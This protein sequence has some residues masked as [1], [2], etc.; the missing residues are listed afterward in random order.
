MMI[1]DSKNYI[2]ADT[3]GSPPVNR[4]C[5]K[6]AEYLYKH[7]DGAYNISER[8]NRFVVSFMLLYSEKNNPKAKLQEMHFNI[9]IAT[10]SNKIRVNLIEISPEERTLFFIAY[11]P[12]EAMVY[13]VVRQKIMD[14]LQ[15]KLRGVYSDYDFVY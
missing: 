6:V 1:N 14:K 13:E 7:I 12:D 2:S 8:A 15:A 4:I 3:K 11:P 5:K 9:D 10:Y